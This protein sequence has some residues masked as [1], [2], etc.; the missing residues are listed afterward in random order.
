LALLGIFPSADANSTFFMQGNG[1]NA[2]RRQ[3]QSNN[4]LHFYPISQE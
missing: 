3:G 2:S 1:F 4:K